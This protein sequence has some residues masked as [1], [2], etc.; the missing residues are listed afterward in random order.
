MICAP[1]REAADKN[2]PKLH[3]KCNVVG[4][5]CQH[6]QGHYVNKETK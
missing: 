2:K 3:K 5:C 4:C 1:C 6:R